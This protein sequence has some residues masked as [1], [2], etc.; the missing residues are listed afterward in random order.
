[1][2]PLFDPQTGSLR[3]DGFDVVVS[4]GLTRTDLESHPDF[5]RFEVFIRNEPWCSFITRDVGVGGELFHVVLWYVDLGPLWRLTLGTARPEIVGTSWGDYDLP[6]SVDFH[7][8]WL[9]RAL[10]LPSATHPRCDPREPYAGPVRQL[11]WAT[12]A[13]GVDPHNGDSEIFVDYR[14]PPR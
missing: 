12:A 1:M 9:D 4:P 13:V 8:S 3:L 14:H 7:E 6:A 5:G 10:G 11:G 2:D